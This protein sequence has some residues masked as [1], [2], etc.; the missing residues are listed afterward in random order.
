MTDCANCQAL[1]QT[2]EALTKAL[3]ES[4]LALVQKLMANGHAPA[5]VSA[6]EML[7]QQEALAEIRRRQLHATNEL[8]RNLGLL[9]NG[10]DFWLDP[11]TGEVYDTP[12]SA[13]DHVSRSKVEPGSVPPPGPTQV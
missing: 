12:E 9:P 3:T 8:A 10:D 1:R 5:G 6:D 2:I 13:R 11:T 4:S 7:K